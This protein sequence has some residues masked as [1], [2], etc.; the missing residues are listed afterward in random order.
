MTQTPISQLSAISPYLVCANATAAI[1]FYK[2]A[3]G[4]SV[5]LLTLTPDKKV[6][7]ATL[8]I[9]GATLM[10]TEEN[11]QFQSISPATLGG[12][13]V[14]IHLSVDDVDE[15][16]AQAQAAG[17]TVVMPPG[18]MFWGDRFSCVKDPFGHSWSLATKVRDM[19][20][21]EIQDAADALFA[22]NQPKDGS[23]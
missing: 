3:F 19:T 11:P 2:E 23:P 10:L 9:N 8:I 14:T 4:A 5:D 21:K 12:S 1:D 15:A 13:P 16:F 20:P 7:H 22:G 17:A 18:D 6:M